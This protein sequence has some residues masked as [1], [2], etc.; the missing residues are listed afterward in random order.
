MQ[1]WHKH[2]RYAL[3]LSSKYSNILLILEHNNMT[4]TDIFACKDRYKHLL[5]LS[6]SCLCMNVHLLGANVMN[7]I[8][9]HLY[10]VP[11][12]IGVSLIS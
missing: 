12:S 10:G 2:M 1:F 11:C 6:I 4:V 5:G 8:Y 3:A 9:Y 7:S